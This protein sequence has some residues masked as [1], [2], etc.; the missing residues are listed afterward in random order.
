MYRIGVDI[1]GTKVK[2]GLFDGKGQR[3]LESCRESVK[4][5]SSLP[6]YVVEAVEALAEDGGV[7][8][9]QISFC[10]VGI[11]GTVSEDGKRILK[12]PN[13]SILSED[14]A[15]EL[16][17]A[18]GI[19]VRLIQDSR[20]AA[21]GEY[22]ACEEKPRSLVCITL[23]TGIGTGLVIGGAIYHGALGSAGE[24]GHLPLRED[25]RPCGCGKRGCVEK[26]CAG[27]GLD[28]TAEEL[29]GAGKDAR[30]LFLAVR[31]GNSSA[32]EALDEAVRG[33]GGAIVAIVNLLSPDRILFSGGLSRQTEQ[34][35]NPVIAYV[36]AHCYSAGALPVMEVASLGEDSPLFGAAFMPIP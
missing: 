6:T 15:E 17:H 33:L 16:E 34:Y 36:R 9:S 13:I 21:W 3:L 7:S 27:G 11:P 22:L 32:A 23:G 2:M 14:L 30:D 1:G 18:L 25:G 35:L 8:L 24:M 10:G 31:E 26:Y 28:R 5:I 19:P 29:L 20:A 4:N 12:A